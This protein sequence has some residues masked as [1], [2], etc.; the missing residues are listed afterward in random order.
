MEQTGNST[1]PQFWFSLIRIGASLALRSMTEAPLRV[2][3]LSLTG[4]L[5][6]VLYSAMTFLVLLPF[7]VVPWAGPLLESPVIT[8]IPVSYFFGKWLARHAPNREFVVF[9][10]TMI[11]RVILGILVLLIDFG[12]NRTNWDLTTFV[13]SILMTFV[14]LQRQRHFSRPAAS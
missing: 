7:L 10:G 9:V 4:I 13:F 1:A 11:P 5:I 2:A 12:P 8:T 14:G 6:Q 3:G